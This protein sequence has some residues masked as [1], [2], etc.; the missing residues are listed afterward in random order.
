[1]KTPEPIVIPEERIQL[2]LQR[3]V[4]LCGQNLV[5]SEAPGRWLQAFGLEDLTLFERYRI[6]W[7]DGT[8]AEKLPTDPKV[9]TEFRQIGLLDVKD[10]EPLSNHAVFA[11]YGGDGRI[12][13]LC[14]VSA[15]GSSTYL[16]GRERGAWNLT[17]TKHSRHI[18]VVSEP[19]D[20]LALVVA[21]YISVIAVDPDA[22]SVDIELL[23][24]RGV[25]RV[26]VVTGDAPEKL[27]AARMLAARFLGIPTDV[28]VIPGTSG[29]CAF[30]KVNGA[31]E[32]SRAI[33]VACAGIQDTEIPNFLPT[34]DGFRIRID[35]REYFSIRLTRTGHQ[36][37]MTLRAH[38]RGRIHVDT[39]DV[40]GSRARKDFVRE[41]ARIFDEPPLHLEQDMEKLLAAAE[42]RSFQPDLAPPMEPIAPVPEALR[43][44]AEIFGKSGDLL[45]RIREHLT[46]I[47]VEGED[48]NKAIAYLAMTSRLLPQP[49]ALKFQ[50][51]FG[52]GKSKVMASVAALCPPEC[53]YPVSYLSAK[54]L[55][56]LERDALKGKCMTIAE[57]DGAED[58][59]YLL[60]E[61]ISSGRLVARFTAR[62]PASGALY[63]DTKEVEGPFSVMLTEAKVNPDEETGSRFMVL[64]SDESRA[65]TQRILERQR[66][67]QGLA[68][69]QE[70][71]ATKRIREL[72]H[73]FQRLLQPLT[74]VIPDDLDVPA[75]DDRLSSRRDWPKIANLIKAVAF[76]RQMQKTVKQEGTTN[77]IEVDCEDVRLAAP[78]I[79]AVFRKPF[80]ELSD[81]SR[82][83]LHA[84]HELRSRSVSAGTPPDGFT[85]T[86]RQVR[87]HT[88]L[89]QTTLHR[90]KEELSRYEFLVR[91][92]N[93]HQRPQRYW[94]DWA[95]VAAAQSG[96]YIPGLQ[97]GRHRMAPDARTPEVFPEN[98]GAL[99]VGAQGPR[100]LPSAAPSHAGTGSGPSLLERLEGGPR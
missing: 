29:M 77:Y 2:R 79:E 75:G 48:V 46:A 59:A 47:G 96:S 43:K 50:G 22:G 14:G 37:K 9:R 54:V 31:S 35:S 3:Y 55:I 5:K 72:H 24:A 20:A 86:L 4:E 17:V 7:S 93:Y 11:V 23:R 67:Q 53:H 65:Q 76:L 41:A 99:P 1:M 100:A 33:T 71:S 15:D 82:N 18:F 83:L 12:Q 97:R 44:E 19:T 74:V 26:T 62:D 69:I 95:P 80:R 51:A 42:R 60:R 28:A 10:R 61:L 36:L 94:L 56:H 6:G 32:L 25:Q 13:T 98:A 30:L 78:L 58:S 92:A 40:Y 91:D 21:R 66:A 88:Q 39:L 57:A 68:G 27:K 87:E 8:L 16:K 81:T 73:A 70:G 64:C 34:P 45:A 63:A 89:P 38:C 49:L 52:V 85:F 90:C 84:I